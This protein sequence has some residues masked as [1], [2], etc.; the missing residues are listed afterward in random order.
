MMLGQILCIII[1]YY[2]YLSHLYSIYV[3]VHSLF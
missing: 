2:L 3:M 1:T